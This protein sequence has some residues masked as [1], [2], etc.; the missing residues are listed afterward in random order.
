MSHSPCIHPSLTP[1]LH[2]THP[3]ITHH[4]P[5]TPHTSPNHSLYLTQPLITLTHPQSPLTP[6]LY[7]THPLITPHSP[8]THL[9]AHSSL[10]LSP[11]P[12][13]TSHSPHIHPSVNL[14]QTP[15]SHVLGQPFTNTPPT[16]CAPFFWLSADPTLMALV[17]SHV[18]NWPQVRVSHERNPHPVCPKHRPQNCPI[19]DPRCCMVQTVTMTSPSRF[20]LTPAPWHVPSGLETR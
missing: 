19:V 2:L 9:L 4:P 7:L 3:L 12:H 15:Y 14:P 1:S 17:V 10:T 8:F 20:R 5:I 11:N 13:S 18:D 16:S 6:S